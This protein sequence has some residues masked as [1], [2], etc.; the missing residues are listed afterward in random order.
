MFNKI[1]NN[2]YN[3]HNIY[4]MRYLRTKWSKYLPRKVFTPLDKPETYGSFGDV[5]FVINNNYNNQHTSRNL[6]YNGI[7]AWCVW[8]K[9]LDRFWELS[10]S[11]GLNKDDFYFMEGGGIINIKALRW[12][13]V[14]FYVKGKNYDIPKLEDFDIDKHTLKWLEESDNYGL[15]HQLLI[16][17]DKN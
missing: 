7:H 9:D 4:L 1:L 14:E 6:P 3:S 11:E 5:L 10:E 15:T 17:V 2:S 16:E 8:E 12:E 13:A